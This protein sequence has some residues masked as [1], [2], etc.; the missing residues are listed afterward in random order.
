MHLGGKGGPALLSSFYPKVVETRGEDE[1]KRGRNNKKC[2][3]INKKIKIKI[4]AAGKRANN[5]PLIST[6]SS[7]TRENKWN[8]SPPSTWSAAFECPR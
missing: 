4:E 5:P 6:P 8:R 2:V 1:E 7:P 3:D